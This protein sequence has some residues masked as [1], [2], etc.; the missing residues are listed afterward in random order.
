[1][2]SGGSLYFWNHLYQNNNVFLDVQAVLKHSSAITPVK[3][4]WAESILLLQH[5]SNNSIKQAVSLMN[6]YVKFSIQQGPH[7]FDE[8][9]L[10]PAWMSRWGECMEGQGWPYFT[11]IQP[12]PRLLTRSGIFLTLWMTVPHRR[13]KF[14][15]PSLIWPTR[16]ARSRS[17]SSQVF[18]IK[19]YSRM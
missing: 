3:K 13:A 14:M 2:E 4:T 10:L 9:T 17:H 18:P 12:H 19:S 6:P 7:A 5:R 15:V 1:M 8:S 11:E 16:M